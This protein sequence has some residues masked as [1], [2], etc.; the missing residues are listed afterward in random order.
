MKRGGSAEEGFQ[1]GCK[2]SPGLCIGCGPVKDR[3]QGSNGQ[4]VVSICKGQGMGTNR[5]EAECFCSKYQALVKTLSEFQAIETK[6]KLAVAVQKIFQFIEL[7][8]LEVGV[9]NL[10][11]IIGH[12]F[13][14][15]PLQR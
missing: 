13:C 3:R 6:I 4:S 5:A 8:S 7:K 2:F 1:V 10:A 9:G 14:C 11:D 12:T 15:L